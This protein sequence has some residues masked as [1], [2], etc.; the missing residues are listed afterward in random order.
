MSTIF[1]NVIRQNLEDKKLLIQLIEGTKTKSEFLNEASRFKGQ[2]QL[3][4]S[5]FNIRRS[6]VTCKHG[7]IYC[8]IKPMFERWGKKC[9]VID[10]EDE[11]PEDKTRVDKKWKHVT[12]GEMIFFPSS[13]DIFL[14]NMESYV[15]VCKQIIAAGHEIMFTTKPHYDA[16]KLFVKLWEG[17]KLDKSKINIYITVSSDDDDVTKEYEPNTTMFSTRLKVIDYLVKHEFTVNAMMEPYLTDPIKLYN[18]VIDHLSKNGIVSMGQMNY[19][20]GLKL[21][22]GQ[23]KYLNDLYDDEKVIKLYN[24]F[25]TNDRVIIKKETA[26]HLMKIFQQKKK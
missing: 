7:C 10:I 12:K 18:E 3:S 21:T 14:E 26:K 2:W 4:D 20:N 25:K 6:D 11:M 8:Y 5:S 17:A 16:I 24:E 9:E 22:D 13:S 1:N 15:K 19:M 23:R